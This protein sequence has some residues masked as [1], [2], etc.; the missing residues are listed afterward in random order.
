MLSSIRKRGFYGNFMLKNEYDLHC[1]VVDFVRNKYPE[2]LMIAGLG[3][4]QK[5]CITRMIS[6]KKGYTSGQADLMIINPTC[7]YNSLCL[8]FKNPTTKNIKLSQKQLEMKELYEKNKCKYVA[9]NNYDD[10]LFEITT[11]MTES[12]MYFKRRKKR[13][14]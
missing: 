2:A 6:W 4:N 1:K 11:H 13:N 14:N 12:N 7:K 10:I 5:N 8:E 9:S 3:E